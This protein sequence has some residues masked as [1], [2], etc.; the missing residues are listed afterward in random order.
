MHLDDL[1]EVTEALHDCDH[2]LVE[3]RLS[4][5]LDAGTTSAMAAVQRDILILEDHKKRLEASAEKKATRHRYELGLSGGAMQRATDNAEVVPHEIP[6][7]LEAGR[8]M[9]DQLRLG[10]LVGSAAPRAREK[11]GDSTPWTSTFES[12]RYGGIGGEFRWGLPMDLFLWSSLSYAVRFQTINQQRP[13]ITGAFEQRELMRL[14]HQAT[15]TF[16]LGW[17]PPHDL[18]MIG[19]YFAAAGMTASADRYWSQ[20]FDGPG[21]ALALGGGLRVL[22]GFPLVPTA[23][24]APAAN[25]AK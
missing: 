8:M 7:A 12:G 19:A 2:T 5:P 21:S 3:I 22:Y 13:A 6:I 15:F 1:T 18:P 25:G 16:G 24:G 20:T 17:K 23:N 11:I 10:V 9:T 4:I 14:S